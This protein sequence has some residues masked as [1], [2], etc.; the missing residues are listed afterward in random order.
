[1]EVNAPTAY[2]V[3]PH[4]TS[5]LIC[6]VVPV[7]ASCGV[8]VAA[9][10]DT[11]PPTAEIAGVAAPSV[12]TVAAVAA[13]VALPA[14]DLK[15]EWEQGGVRIGGPPKQR[16]RKGRC[17]QRICVP[18][19]SPNITTKSKIAPSRVFDVVLS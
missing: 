11:G 12:K 10:A 14:R 9:T 16:H 13:N 3:P 1:M 6:C 5:C 19:W 8:Q 18:G 7:L 15:T 2:I 4:C 17:V